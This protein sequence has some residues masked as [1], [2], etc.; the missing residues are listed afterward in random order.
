MYT[1]RG[2]HQRKNEKI[3]RRAP[4]FQ[5][6]KGNMSQPRT[7]AE[8]TKQKNTKTPKRIWAERPSRISSA[9]TPE[10]RVAKAVRITKWLVIVSRLSI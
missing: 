6:G 8:A 1:S 10:T 9:N 2:P 5:E 4:V 3:N 7:K